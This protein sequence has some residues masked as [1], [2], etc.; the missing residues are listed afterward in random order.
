[1]KSKVQSIISILFLLFILITSLFFMGSSP[2]STQDNDTPSLFQPNRWCGNFPAIPGAGPLMGHASCVLGD[3][4][5]VAGGNQT[6]GASIDFIRYAITGNNWTVGNE[7][8]GPKSGGDLVAA[9]GKIY[10]IGGG[11]LT[12]SGASNEQYVYDPV[13]GHWSTIANIPSPVTGNVAESYQDSLIY[14]IAGGWDT[15]LQTVQVY[16]IRT[17]TWTTATQLPSGK[18]RR[19]FAGGLN[20]NKIFVACG[21]SNGFKNDFIIGTISSTNRLNITWSNGPNLA[22]NSSRPGG[23]AIAG[24]FY[25]VFGETTVN[26]NGNDS[27]AIW[28]TTTASWSYIDGKPLRASN[29]WGVVSASFV[30]CSG[31][32]GIKIWVPGG[33]YNST[34]T[35]PLDVFSD[36]CMKGCGTIITGIQPSNEIPSQFE[37]LQNYPNPF[38]PSTKIMYDLPSSSSV[39]LLVYDI[40]GREVKVLVDKTEQAGKHSVDFVPASSL[41]SGIYFYK[42]E[43]GAY[44]ATKKML[45][46]K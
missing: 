36:T 27:M 1:M 46:I 4:L 7:M 24:R 37:L 23:T 32:E 39:R 44:S 41:S 16:R 38:N 5:Y 26:Q 15:Y 34:S 14:C 43:T 6:G 9:G 29:Y 42:L 31:R 40:N 35:R 8:P 21:Y 11:N 19:S 2:Y 33:A 25:V 45:Y 3:T 22:I 18:G 13:T 12:Y 20:G 10:Y 28:D 17:N 30:N